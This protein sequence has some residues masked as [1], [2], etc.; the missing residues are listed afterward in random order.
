[1]RKETRRLTECSLL[2]AIAVVLYLSTLVPGIG[3]ITILLCCI[4]ATYVTLLHGVRWG[5]GSST[6]AT[7]LITM[8]YGPMEGSAY[9]LTFAITGISLGYLTSRG[10]PPSVILLG[11]TLTVLLSM[12]LSVYIVESMLGLNET[13]KFFEEVQGY[14]EYSQTYTD[15]VLAKTG[16][17]EQKDPAEISNQTKVL[18]KVPLTL[19]MI[20]SFLIVYGNYVAAALV[21]RRLGLPWEE[22]PNPLLLQVP[23]F[24]TP[25]AAASYILPESIFSGGGFVPSILANVLAVAWFYHY[26][27]GF[28]L[29][30][31]SFNY[32]NLPVYVRFP[33]MI[34]L[35]LPLRGILVTTAAIDAFADVRKLRTNTDT[36]VV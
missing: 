13:G 33:V 11:S 6:V 8:T 30:A 28:S 24:L 2:T 17:F 9:L 35:I 1:M 31:Y 18:M 15:L 23:R 25:F 29:M 21:F 5:I 36:T 3:F 16:L 14:I 34:I 27:A 20:M 32:Y 10:H 22:V 12:L 26:M 4:P 19:F 7:V